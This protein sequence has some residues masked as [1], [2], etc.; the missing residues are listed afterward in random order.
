MD[1]NVLDYT[2]RFETYFPVT[3]GNFGGESPFASNLSFA[4]P[5]TIIQ[6]MDFYGVTKENILQDTNINLLRLTYEMATK[7][8]Q[9]IFEYML[10]LSNKLGGRLTDNF[11]NK[12]FVYQQIIG[13]ES[14]MISDNAQ[15]Q[16]DFSRKIQLLRAER[17]KYEISNNI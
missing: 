11:N 15:Q 3:S 7:S 9:D 12:A 17:Q 4:P 6:M 2:T 8:G 13:Q 10:E 1:T 5:Q 16:E 14:R